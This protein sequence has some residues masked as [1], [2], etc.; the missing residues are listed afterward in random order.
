M[1]PPYACIPPPPPP[2]SRYRPPPLTP[3]P[4][5]PPLPVTILPQVAALKEAGGEARLFDWNERGRP[6]WADTSE[7]VQIINTKERTLT[8]RAV[9][10]GWSGFTTVVQLDACIEPLKE[11]ANRLMV[12]FH[13][14]MVNVGGIKVTFPHLQRFRCVF[15]VFACSYVQ[16]YQRVVFMFECAVFFLSRWVSRLRMSFCLRRVSVGQQ[17]GNR[18]GASRIEPTPPSYVRHSIPRPFPSS[19]HSTLP[20][21]SSSLLY[22]LAYDPVQSYGMARDDV[23]QPRPSHRP[24]EQGV[25]LRPDATPGFVQRTLRRQT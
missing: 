24:G 16:A 9:Y 14:A 18:Y 7:S 5:F 21:P 10:K 22:R 2:T 3:I 12:G 23:C 8:N 11:K 13:K 20:I 25:H 1:A 4:P 19:S 17:T 15:C 6:L